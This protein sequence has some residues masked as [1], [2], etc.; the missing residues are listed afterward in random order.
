MKRFNK[1]ELNQF[2]TEVIEDVLQTLKAYNHVTISFANG[3]HHV[4]TGSCILAAYPAD[5]KVFGMAYAEDVYSE[6]ERTENYIEVFQ[7]YPIW[8]KGSRD[9]KVLRERFGK[10]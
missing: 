4:S 1:E 5:H 8:Y 6:E 9:Y 7:D 3:L 2:P 10:N